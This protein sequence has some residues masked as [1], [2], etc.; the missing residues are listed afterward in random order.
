MSSNADPQQGIQPQKGRLVSQF[1]NRKIAEHG[2]G[3]SDLWDSGDSGLWDR[4]IPSPALV[5]LLEEFSGG[6]LD[7]LMDLQ[8][9]LGGKEGGDKMEKK[10]SKRR[11]RALVPGCGLGYDVLSLALHGFDAYGL[12][13]SSTAVSEAKEYAREEMNPDSQPQ[14]QF[15]G[16]DCKD[17][18]S[19]SRLPPG[20]VTF[21]KG[22]FFNE[23]N[24]W[25]GAGLELD[26]LGDELTFDVIY[27]YTFLCALHPTKRPHW[28]SRMAELLKPGGLLICLEF[29]M[30]KD[31]SLPG[32]PW[33]VNG[34]HWKLLAREEGGMFR[35]VL[36]R[37]PERTFEV[38]KGTDWVSVWERC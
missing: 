19:Q 33:G 3:W 25:S 8:L 35:R 28:A 31:P 14:A 11:K 15:F 18:Q 16:Q 1:E 13:I 4:G 7:P 9:G 12:E 30:Y 24:T 2:Q 17:T 10:R 38:G 22:D 27:D 26:T 32:P 29:P 20:A 21:M 34:V 23:T 36:S 5:D 37:M 6:L